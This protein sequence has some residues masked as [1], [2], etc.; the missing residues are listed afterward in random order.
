MGVG[1]GVGVH[2]LAYHPD[3]SDQVELQVLLL[4]HH[5]DALRTQHKF[6]LLLPNGGGVHR[7]WPYPRAGATAA[8]RGLKV[9][10]PA[11]VGD[12]ADRRLGAVGVK[13][14]HRVIALVVPGQGLDQVPLGGGADVAP[15]AR[16]GQLVHRSHDPHMSAQGQLSPEA[17]TRADADGGVGVARHLPLV[18]TVILKEEQTAALRSHV[19]EEALPHAQRGV[20]GQEGFL[21]CLWALR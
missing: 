21:R 12:P 8:R 15:R 17:V 3:V 9:G 14:R 19:Q 5:A 11:G 7:K 6:R 18:V 4:Q 10:A 20:S 16:S 2:L 13:G 1:G